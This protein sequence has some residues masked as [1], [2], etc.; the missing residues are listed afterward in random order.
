MTKSSGDSIAQHVGEVLGDITIVDEELIGIEAP[1]SM[2]KLLDD[3][4]LQLTG[5]DVLYD[6]LSMEEQ[7]E[8]QA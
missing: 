2:T 3:S 7:L 8:A 4:H 5:D 6:G 1:R